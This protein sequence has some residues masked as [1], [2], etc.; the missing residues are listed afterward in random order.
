MANDQR[1]LDRQPGKL[2]F[3]IVVGLSLAAVVF[4]L[5]EEHRVHLLGALPWVI[6]LGACLLMHVFMHGGHGGHG[7]HG[8]NGDHQ[9][10]HKEDRDE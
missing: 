2:R 10:P 3:W 1:W 5:W 7:G 4:L 8:T 6:L 9:A